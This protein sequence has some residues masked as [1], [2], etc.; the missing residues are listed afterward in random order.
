M[1]IEGVLRFTL[2]LGDR[3][4]VPSHAHLIGGCEPR[5]QLYC[6]NL[7]PIDHHLFDLV[8]TDLGY[9]RSLP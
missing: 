2:A 3:L 4:V 1:M 7:L 5:C 8:P 9:D 6:Q